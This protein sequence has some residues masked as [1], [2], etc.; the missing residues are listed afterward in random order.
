MQYIQLVLDLPIRG[1]YLQAKQRVRVLEPHKDANKTGRIL[2]RLQFKSGTLYLVNLPG[3]VI[4][5]TRA[6]LEAIK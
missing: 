4:S 6:E 2:M 1:F 5:A 3:K